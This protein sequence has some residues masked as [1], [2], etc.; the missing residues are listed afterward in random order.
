MAS[1]NDKKK[2]HFGFMED[3]TGKLSDPLV[4]GGILVII[5]LIVVAVIMWQKQKTGVESLTET[6]TKYLL[7]NTP[8]LGGYN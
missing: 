2:E 7:T 8:E 3:I 5:I 4:I 6:A 1:P